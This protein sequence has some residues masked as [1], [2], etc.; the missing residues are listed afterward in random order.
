MVYREIVDSPEVD[1]TIEWN[2]RGAHSACPRFAEFAQR[3]FRELTA[4][5]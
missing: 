2:T 3:Y 1:V 4:Q 5:P